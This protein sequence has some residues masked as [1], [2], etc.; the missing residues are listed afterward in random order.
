MHIE[1]DFLI[2]VPMPSEEWIAQATGQGGWIFLPTIS[3]KS[4]LKNIVTVF[5]ISFTDA[6]E[7]YLYGIDDMLH[8]KW[9]LKQ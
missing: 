7:W 8:S 6:S 5:E 9:I 1:L 2:F 3:T 4:E